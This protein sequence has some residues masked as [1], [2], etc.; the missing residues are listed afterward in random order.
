MGNFL[1]KL[2]WMGEYLIA[3]YVLLLPLY[4]AVR[5]LYFLW[6]R[7]HPGAVWTRKKTWICVAVLVVLYAAVCVAWVRAHMH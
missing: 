1:S 5:L 7:R 6:A 2:S 4:G 3:G